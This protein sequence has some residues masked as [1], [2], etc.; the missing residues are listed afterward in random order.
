MARCECCGNDYDT[1]FTVTISGVTHTFDSFECAIF[2][3]APACDH[4]G[5]RIVG[6][7]MEGQRSLFLLCALRAHGGRRVVEGSRADR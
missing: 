3:V 5:C 6:H 2:T 1:C 7:G 4:C